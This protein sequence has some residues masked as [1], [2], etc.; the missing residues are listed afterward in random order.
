MPVELS[1]VEAAFVLITVGLGALIQGSLGFGFAFAV[2]PALAL[3]RPEAVPAT[4]VLLS[5]PMV[6]LMAIRERG[7]IRIR[8]FLWITAG[9]LPGTVVGAWILV[10]L[11][12]SSLGTA[13]GILILVGVVMSTVGPSFEARKGAQFLGGVASGIMGTMGTA[14]GIGSPPL[15]LVNQNR[16]GAQLRSTLA[17]SFVVGTLISLAALFRVGMVR[18]WHV[19]FALELLPGLL[20]GLLASNFA[21]PLLDRKWLRPALLTFAGCAAAI[22]ILRSYFGDG[23]A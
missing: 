16:P 7:S 10:V 17:I 11:P 2:A 20:L 8:D 14:A 5:I 18:E 15:A 6:A 1:V 9:R 4:I 21:I 13:F 23:P 19:L 22:T 3:V 12:A